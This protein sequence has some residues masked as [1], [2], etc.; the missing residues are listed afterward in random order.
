MRR[1]S[2]ALLALAVVGGGA[3][4]FAAG[5]DKPSSLQAMLRGTTSDATAGRLAT[6]SMQQTD[7]ADTEPNLQVAQALPE[8][9]TAAQPPAV[10]PPLVDETALRYFAQQHDT[11]RLEAEIARLRALYPDWTPPA[12][13]LAI[14]PNSDPQLDAMWKLYSTGELAALR[15]AIADRRSA[16]P[17]WQV[18]AD[19]AQRLE[20]AEGRERLVNASNLK[21]YATVIRV[22]SDYPSLLTCADVDVLWRV[23]EAF[24]STDR[25]D[26]AKDAYLYIL[27]SC[28]DPGER[29]ATVQKAAPLLSRDAMDDLLATERTGAD[30]TGEFAQARTDL[31]RRSVAEAGKDPAASVRPGD[32]ET[33]EAAA[34]KDGLASD[35]LLLGWYFLLRN[36]PTKAAEWFGRAKETSP[37]AEAAQGYSLALIRLDRPAEAEDAL[38]P[39]RSETKEIQATYLAAVANMLAVEPRI[40]LKPEVLQRIVPPIV[41]AKDS[42]AA[43]QMGWYARALDQHQT[44]GKWFATVL[45]W[46]P[47]DEASAYGLALTRLQ[48]GDRAGVAELQRL[49][50][51]RSERIAILGETRRRPVPG[52]ITV[53]QDEVVQAAPP[54]RVQ[55]APPAGAQAAPRP[56]PRTGSAARS[57]PQRRSCTSTQLAGTATGQAALDRGWCLMELDRPAEAVT[58][59]DA[60]LATGNRNVRQDAAWGQSLAYLRIG[61][62]DEAAVA[63]AKAP[64]PRERA[65]ELEAS[66]LA[67]RATSF[68][69]AERYA[70]ALLALDQRAQVSAERRDLM[71]L[72]GYAYLKL[73]RLSDARQV[74]EALAAAGDR[75]GP[76]GIA[77]VKEAAQ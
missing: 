65:A 77:A 1:A 71:A 3:A 52:E 61:L 29:L 49:W 54:A 69:E 13:P 46:K 8:G 28:D 47:D 53:S 10:T 63:A 56:A 17:A 58:A 39:W 62:T 75:E 31:A 35:D 24:V 74:F 4:Y 55:A 45:K 51:G 64:Q 33:V 50:A 37:T 44:A 48:L 57:A 23:A 22:A 32:L 36:D 60:A 70:E 6:P 30:G 15:K 72:R 34:R 66:I 11:R 38:Y 9:S 7:A 21:Q 40:D 43:Q 19:L 20:V 25:P 67:Q 14:P 41:E 27:R 59:F 2:V 16:E 76:R 73:G 18:P 68:F 42:A 26:R 12:D 5:Q